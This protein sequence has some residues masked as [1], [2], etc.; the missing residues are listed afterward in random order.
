MEETTAMKKAI[1]VLYLGLGMA[2][3]KTIANKFPTT[4]IARITL[5]ELLKNWEECFEKPKNETLDRFKF[6]SSKQQEETLGQFW[7]EL[8]GVAAKGNFGG[9]TESLVKDVFNVNMINKDVQQKVS[10]EP[11]ATVQE[12]IDFAIAYGEGTIRQKWFD[13]LEKPNVKIEANEI[14]N[15]N[16]SGAKWWGPSKKCFRCEANFLPQHSKECKARGVTC[17]KC[18]KKDHFAKCCQTKGAGNFAKSRKVIKSPQQHKQR[19]D[20]WDESSKESTTGDDKIVLTI[21]GD[22]N[23]QFTMS[24]K[25]NGNPFKTM[26]DSGYPLPYSK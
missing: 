18:G 6:L 23:G 11:K 16:Q 1:S 5:R 26:V 7:K 12:N 9:I 19:I 21:E 24:G 25:M 8:D 13:K 22:E 4:N 15:I 17:M 3:R 10:T 14:N 20:E 2:A